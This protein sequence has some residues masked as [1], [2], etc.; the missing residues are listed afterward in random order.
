MGIER[1]KEF[2]RNEKLEGLLQQINALLRT[3]ENRILE[4]YRMPK[5]PL[6]LLVGCPRAGSTLMM[7]WLARKGRFAYPTNLL[8]RFYGAVYIGALIQQLLTASEFNFNNEILDFNSEISF[9]SNLGKTKGALA[10][11]EFWYFWRR[12]FPYG[13]IQYLDD[14][15]LER[16]DTTKFVAELAAAE[17]VF[18][19][20]FILKGLIIN[21]NIPFVSSLFDKVLFLHIKRNPLYNTQSLLE[22]RVKFYGDRKAWY[23]FKPIEYDQLKVLDPYEQAAGQVYFTNK[24]VEKGL[25]QIDSARWLQVSYEEFCMTPERVFHQ[26]LDKLD[27]QGCKIER[28]YNGPK[29][30][31]NTNEI[32][33]SVK[34]R[35][36]IIQAYKRFSKS[37]LTF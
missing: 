4:H 21:W 28:S 36:R 11:N 20:P 2:Q 35:R 24:A 25:N 15:S 5:Y 32:R 19:K 31:H 23:S 29:L 6:V 37:D 8:S 9:S 13:E 18:D 14:R 17:S 27:L 33:C 34:E 1:R 12:F 30:F 26:I 22:A 16:I 7:Q 10:P 3:T